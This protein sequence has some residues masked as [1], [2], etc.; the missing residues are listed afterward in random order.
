[1]CSSEAASTRNSKRSRQNVPRLKFYTA[2]VG[3]IIVRQKRIIITNYCP[4][5]KDKEWTICPESD[6]RAFGGGLENDGVEG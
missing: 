4:P 5:G 6:I 3:S 2:V 1:M